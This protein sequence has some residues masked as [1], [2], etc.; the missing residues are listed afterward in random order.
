MARQRIN[1]RYRSYAFLAEDGPKF[2]TGYSICIAFTILSMIATTLY[3]IGCWHANRQRDAR[4]GEDHGLTA[5][6]KADLGDLSPDYRY[7]L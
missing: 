7:L 5:E 4:R 6:E 2:V 3:A 1:L